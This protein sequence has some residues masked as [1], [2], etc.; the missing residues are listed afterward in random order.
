VVV[1]DTVGR[2]LHNVGNHPHPEAWSRVAALLPAA[3]RNDSASVASPFF[4]LNQRAYFWSVAS[5]HS[6]AQRLGYVAQLRAVYTNPAATRTLQGLIGADNQILFVNRDRPR[7]PW[8]QLDGRAS[9]RGEAQLQEA[10][11]VRYERG[12]KKYIAGR[13]Q[14]GSTPWEIVVE[15]PAAIANARPHEFLRRTGVLALLLLLAAGGLVWAGSRRIT[16][17]IREL[18]AAAHSIARGDLDRRVEIRR[19]DELGALGESFNQM[20]AEVQRSMHTAEESRAEAQRANR[21][22]SEFLANMSHEIR[23]PINAILGYTDLL[24]LGVSGTINDEQRAQLERIRVSGNHLIGL[25]DD[26]LDFAR[27]DVASMAVDCRAFPAEQSMRTALTVVTPQAQAKGVAIDVK[28]EPGARYHGDPQR[29]EQILVNLLGNA[30][31][32]TGRGGRVE[33]SC[34]SVTRSGAARV[35]FTISDT[36]IGI[37]PDRIEA[38][39]EPFVQAS[40]GYT[41]PHG[42]TGLGLSISRRLAELMGGQITVESEVG[43]GS[44]FTLILPVARA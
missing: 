8:V 17:P 2:V 32:F 33:L 4:F 43:V 37:P 40:S 16:R 14:L 6:D 41:R 24:D 27:L 42:G 36:G 23:T 12:G 1:I 3:A 20:A 44:R 39:F 31:K 22:K 19:A 13:N 35:A 5:V 30:I 9:P 18:H 21:A 38:I 25:V 10:P 28:C 29:V 26:L 7:D 34:E 15:T 11:G